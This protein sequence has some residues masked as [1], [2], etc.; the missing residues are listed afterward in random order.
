MSQGRVIYANGPGQDK[1]AF[2]RSL[3]DS[4]WRARSHGR[5]LIENNSLL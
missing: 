1:C 4:F 2:A 3:L 5:I